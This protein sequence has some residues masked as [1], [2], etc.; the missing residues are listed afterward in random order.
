MS[1]EPAKPEIIFLKATRDGLQHA[2]GC[3]HRPLLQWPKSPSRLTSSTGTPPLL[4]RRTK[5]PEPRNVDMAA[6]CPNE[7]LVNACRFFDM[8]GYGAIDTSFQ[9]YPVTLTHMDHFHAYPVPVNF[10]DL[11]QLD[12]DKGLLTFHP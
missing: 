4:T 2:R 10:F 11:C 1:N 5:G 7:K 8:H 12:I 3:Q 9:P 6:L